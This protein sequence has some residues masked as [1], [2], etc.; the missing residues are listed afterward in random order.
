MAFSVMVNV[1]V[2]VLLLVII[3]HTVGKALP[4]LYRLDNG[5]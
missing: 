5:Y 2:V 1:D 4:Q 3:K